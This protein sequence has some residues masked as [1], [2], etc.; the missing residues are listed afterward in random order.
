MTPDRRRAEMIEAATAI[1]LSEG[2]DKLT[3][4]R[5]ATAIG[6]FPGLVSHYFTADELAAAAFARTASAERD[7]LYAKAESADDPEQQVRR[8]LAAWLHPAR[9]A[10]S[11]LW[12]DAWQASR[13]RPALRDEVAAQMKEDS[14]RLGR[15]ISR[16][17][18][19]GQ[20]RADDAESAAMQI[21]SLVDGLSVQAA[22]RG[23]LDYEVVRTLVTTV[24]E[25]ILGLA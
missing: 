18:D 12:I 1:A 11:L 21:M 25:Q 6:V 5:V 15:L 8:L 3:A 20:F 16:G 19:S 9:D 23:A 7:E 4:K 13:R 17:I 2:L 24:A 10:V 14:Q 22:V